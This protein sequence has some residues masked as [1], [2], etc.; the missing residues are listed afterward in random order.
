MQL[1][2][3]TD[4]GRKFAPLL[5]LDPS[6]LLYLLTTP[7]P[8]FQCCRFSRAMDAGIS[9]TEAHTRQFGAGGDTVNSLSFFRLDSC[10]AF[11]TFVGVVRTFV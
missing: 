3:N 7:S 11:V 4:I 2:L 10:D 5:Q 6:V 1:L 9:Q 8:N